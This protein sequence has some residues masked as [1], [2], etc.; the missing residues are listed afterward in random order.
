M[1][2]HKLPV[3]C[4]DHIALQQSVS[5]LVTVLQRLPGIRIGNTVNTSQRMHHQIITVIPVLPSQSVLAA[6]VGTDI[7]PDHGST[8][9]YCHKT[10]HHI[11]QTPPVRSLQPSVHDQRIKEYNER[12]NHNIFDKQYPLVLQTASKRFTYHCQRQDSIG[13]ADPDR[14]CQKKG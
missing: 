12:R 2:G 7:K 13:P 11:S 10:S 4:H 9:A 3:R 5:L 6:Y 1:A 14:S 8:D